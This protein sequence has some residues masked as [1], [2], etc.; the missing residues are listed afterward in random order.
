MSRIAD[1]GKQAPDRETAR[2][3][4]LAAWQRPASQRVRD[5]LRV[6]R[7]TD[8]RAAMAAVDERRKQKPAVAAR[9]PIG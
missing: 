3:A 6:E 5:Q 2:Q 8:A 9:G 4:R 7:I 1:P